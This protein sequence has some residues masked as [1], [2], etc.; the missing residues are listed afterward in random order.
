MSD[1]R[2]TVSS[3]S[4][5]SLGAAIAVVLSWDQWH[6]VWWAFIHGVL[7]WFYVL[8]YI[9]SGRRQ[10]SEPIDTPMSRAEVCEWLDWSARTLYAKTRDE[11]FPKFRGRRIFRSQVL[12]WFAGT[13]TPPH[14]P[15]T[16][17][18]NR[19]IGGRPRKG[20]EIDLA[21]AIAMD[22]RFCGGV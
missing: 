6:S 14:K 4:G 13:I 2:R 12:S 15:T 8:Y 18:G 21:S 9:F 16:L 17:G 10:V 19:G 11:G 5:I 1:E 7:G 22:A 20:K 3:S